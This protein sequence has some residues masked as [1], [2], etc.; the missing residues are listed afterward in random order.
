MDSTAPVDPAAQMEPATEPVRRSNSRGNTAAD[1]DP[2]G[3]ARRTRSEARAAAAREALARIPGVVV[4]LGEEPLVIKEL[5]DLEECAENYRHAIWAARVE[6]FV[7]TVAE[8]RRILTAMQDQ[9]M[10]DAIRRMFENKTRAEAPLTAA[11]KKAAD[12]KKADDEAAKKKAAEAEAAKKKA[13]AAKKT[14]DEDNAAKKKAAD[15]AA[16]KRAEEASAKAAAALRKEEEETE[17]AIVVSLAEAREAREAEERRA[18]VSA[19]EMSQPTLGGEWMEDGESVAEIPPSAAANGKRR[20]RDDEPAATAPQATT[21]KTAAEKDPKTNR[22]EHEGTLKDADKHPKPV[23]MPARPIPACTRQ[24]RGQVCAAHPIGKTLT[25][26]YFAQKNL[27]SLVLIL[28]TLVS[29]GELDEKFLTFLDDPLAHPTLTNMAPMRHRIEVMM[30]SFE[31][32]QTYNE[33]YAYVYCKIHDISSNG[34]TMLHELVAMYCICMLNLALPY[35][36]LVY[37]LTTGYAGVTCFGK[38]WASGARIESA[39]TRQVE[40]TIRTC[41]YAALMVGLPH[42]VQT[43]EMIV[44]RLDF[45]Q[46]VEKALTSPSTPRYP[47]PATPERNERQTT[48]DSANRALPL[49]VREKRVCH[50]DEL[51]LNCGRKGH[52]SRACAQPKHPFIAKGCNKFDL[53]NMIANGYVAIPN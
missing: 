44:G 51:C 3:V 38:D 25:D 12:K 9:Q 52:L 43:G 41:Q 45:M 20:T 1:I 6:I 28:H 10:E 37:L 32:A 13:D 17:R 34:L 30:N 39:V 29:H 8:Y 33:A 22:P 2:E 48:A 23:K 5:A 42:D 26:G 4:H 31:F 15:D 24:T 35:R 53:V 7:A 46:Q 16:K 36:A 19:R 18:R 27:T 14:T 40:R 21:K 47:V 11:Q 49:L 50:P